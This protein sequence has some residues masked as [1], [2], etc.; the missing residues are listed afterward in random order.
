MTTTVIAE[1][2]K[3]IRKN[4]RIKE[5]REKSGLTTFYPQKKICGIWWNF[6]SSLLSEWIESFATLDEAKAFLDKYVDIK[7]SKRKVTYHNVNY[8]TH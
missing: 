1:K 4:L 6:N 3:K 2:E 8:L 5:V 7:L